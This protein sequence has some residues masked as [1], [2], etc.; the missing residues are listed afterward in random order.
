MYF[1][2]W[3]GGGGGS[4]R[5]IFF[6]FRF[7]FFCGGTLLILVQHSLIHSHNFFHVLGG[8][9]SVGRC[10]SFVPGQRQTAE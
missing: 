9:V 7:L 2:F 8:N 4:Y 10:V 3:G 1:F 5:T 6:N